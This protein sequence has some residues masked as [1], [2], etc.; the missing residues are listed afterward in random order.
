MM[1]VFAPTVPAGAVLGV[2]LPSESVRLLGALRV[3]F[4]RWF[5]GL[6]RFAAGALCEQG[7]PGVGIVRA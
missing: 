7:A 6:S 1:P 3:T 2:P 5:V 4:L